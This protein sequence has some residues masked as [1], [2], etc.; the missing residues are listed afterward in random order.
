VLHGCGETAN[1][2][3]ELTGWNKLA[4]TNDFIVLYPQQKFVN[5]VDVCFNWFMN[6][7]IEKGKG[8]CESIIQMIVYAIANYPVDENRIFITGFS[9]GAAMAVVMTA[10]H[11]EFFQSGAIF[12]GG[13]YHMVNNPF[14]ALNAMLGKKK[15]NEEKL[16]EVVRDQNP[17]YKGEYPT[18]IIYQGSNDPVVNVRNAE[19]LVRQWTGIHDADTIRDKTEHAYMGINDITRSEYTDASGRTIVILYEVDNLGHRILVKPGEKND[20]GGHTGMFSVDKGFHSTY[21]TAKE[22]GIIKMN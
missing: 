10:T 12:A 22:F 19:I 5:N 21:Q 18:L 13:A 16:A 6:R 11:P 14:D 8:E 15:V 9:A 17:G 4:D 7:D 20:E 2:V 3:A 1:S